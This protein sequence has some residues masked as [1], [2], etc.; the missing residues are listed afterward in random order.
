MLLSAY[1]AASACS[2]P[3]IRA[4]TFAHSALQIVLPFQ[5]LQRASAVVVSLLAAWN[6]DAAVHMY[7]MNACLSS[8]ARKH[9]GC[10]VDWDFLGETQTHQATTCRI[11]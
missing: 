7:F 8:Y 4:T 11:P 2:C 6:M 10:S 9:S 3:L 5:P 1:S